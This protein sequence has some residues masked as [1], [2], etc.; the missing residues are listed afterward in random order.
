M[1]RAGS[2]APPD[3]HDDEDDDED[4]ENVEPMRG[5]Y[6]LSARGAGAATGMT[7][8][9]AVCVVRERRDLVVDEAGRPRRPP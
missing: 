5:W 6:S 9:I 1:L 4:D 3:Q 8:R 7:S 2:S